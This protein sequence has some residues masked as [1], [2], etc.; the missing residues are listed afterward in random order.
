MQLCALDDV[1]VMKETWI[2]SDAPNAINLD[3]SPTGYSAVYRH[4]GSSADRRGGYHQS[5]SH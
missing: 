3:V 4:R 1:R 2:P 5:V